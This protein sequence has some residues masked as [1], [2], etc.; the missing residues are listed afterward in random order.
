MATVTDALC[1]HILQQEVAFYRSQ[2]WASNTKKTYATHRKCYLSFCSAINV[3]P[4]PATATV[5]S[6][7]AAYLARRLCYKS[8]KQ[9]MNIVRILHLEWG[10]GNPLADNFHLHT[11]LQGIRRHK[12]DITCRKAPITPQLLLLLQN[13]LNLSTPKDACLWAA[14]LLMFFGLLRRSN[15]LPPSR[16]G[17]DADRHLR[18]CDVSFSSEGTSVRVRWSKTIQFRE[19]E[20][21]LP[22]PR[23]CN[24]PLCPTT[25]LFHAF[26]LSPEAPPQGPALVYPVDGR[27]AALTSIQFV[28]LIKAKLQ[29][30]CP[31]QDIAGHSFRRGGAC[32]AYSTG[33]P[34]DTIRQLGDW[35]SNAYTDYTICDTSMLREAERVM[36]LALPAS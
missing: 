36:S 24:H 10:L 30:H 23:I 33:V 25:A 13:Q 1:L 21:L 3:S 22:L 4:V 29:G 27:L 6:L 14:A 8:V 18:R 15:V 2:C 20:L 16:G 7:Y 17:F 9:Y 12:G 5:L 32:W 28:E 26:R 11:T 34:I 35:R 31:V 19:R